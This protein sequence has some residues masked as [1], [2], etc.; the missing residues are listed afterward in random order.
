MHSMGEV[1]WLRIF[2][3]LVHNHY[4]IVLYTLYVCQYGKM[5]LKPAQCYMELCIVMCSVYVIAHVL[6]I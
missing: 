6:I 2:G 1:A 3:V 5:D 4:D